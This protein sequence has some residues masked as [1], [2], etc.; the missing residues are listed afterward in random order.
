MSLVAL[1]WILNRPGVT[2][3]LAGIRSIQQLDDNLAGVSLR[4]P[5]EIITRLDHLTEP[6]L[7][8]LGA[9]PDYFQA[10]DHGRTV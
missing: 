9:S 4:L 10:R 2:C 8:L 1:A 7:H 6:L 3:I 5:P